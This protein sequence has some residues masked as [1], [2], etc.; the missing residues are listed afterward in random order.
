VRRFSEAYKRDMTIEKRIE[1]R[2]PVKLP[3]TLADG[4]T[5]TTRD[6]SA[7]G[8]FFE[9]DNKL[10]LGSVIDFRIELS[11]NG[12]SMWLKE[13]AQVVRIETR[14]KRTGIAARMLDSH[15][16]AAN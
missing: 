2:E 13:R 9:I 1:A 6:V 8:L 16:E 5:G 10:E 15:L 3:V 4:S 7:T 12:R 11:T 14:G